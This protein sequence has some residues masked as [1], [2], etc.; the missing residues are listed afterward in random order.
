MPD[1]AVIRVWDLES[2]EVRVL[3]AGDGLAILDLQFLPDLRL[4]SSGRGGLRL[5]DLETETYELIREEGV[6]DIELSRDGRRLLMMV[7]GGRVHVHDFETGDSRLLDTGESRVDSVA[8]DPTGT[9]VVA[10]HDDGMV[11]VGPATGGNRHQLLGHSGS[12]S[13]TVSRDGRWIASGGGRDGTVRLW[14]M[15]D[16]TRP[17][18]HM[19]PHQEFLDRLGRLTNLRVVADE[20]SSTGYRLHRDPFPGWEAL[21]T[22]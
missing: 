1:H 14:A 2:D 13:V 17:P 8:F 22:W 5:W 15:P 21:P 18:L 6:G 19:V 20:D 16:L 12:C 11:S 10:G 9:I 4:L 3:D 7:K